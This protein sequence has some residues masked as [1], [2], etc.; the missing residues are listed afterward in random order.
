MRETS[1]GQRLF[2]QEHSGWGRI[3]NR[4]GSVNTCT[5]LREL[6]A[7]EAFRKAFLAVVLGCSQHGRGGGGT[8]GPMMPL[9]NG[10]AAESWLCVGVLPCTTTSSPVLP[11][12]QCNCERLNF[13]L[14][15]HIRS[16]FP[17][18]VSITLIY[19]QLGLFSSCIYL[20]VHLFP[21]HKYLLLTVSLEM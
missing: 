10:A 6:S 13:N 19:I 2:M 3:A 1:E 9:G 5:Q 12:Q 21:G 7:G 8:S 16:M 11:C 4:A 15:M 18:S 17:L 20:L 14:W